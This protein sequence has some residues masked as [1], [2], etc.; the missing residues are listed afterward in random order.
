MLPSPSLKKPSSR[1][2][3][4]PNLSVAPSSAAAVGHDSSENP[5]D[6]DRARVLSQAADR[7]DDD[8][9]REPHPPGRSTSQRERRNGQHERQCTEVQGG[10][11]DHRVHS[12]NA[13]RSGPVGIAS[14]LTTPQVRAEHFDQAI[15][16]DV[17]GVRFVGAS[18]RRTS[19]LLRELNDWKELGRGSR[20]CQ[21]CG[22]SQAEPHDP[23]RTLPHS[24]APAAN[25]E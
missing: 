11:P 17:E 14:K 7:A 15:G 3:L 22:T 25:E 1:I 4:V 2:G 8:D 23:E 5:R 9:H 13:E 19:G 18:L 24:A 20:G 10:Y 21:E 12:G 16:L 6:P